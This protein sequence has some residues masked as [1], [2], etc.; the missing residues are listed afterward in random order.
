M[1]WNMLNEWQLGK[2]YGGISVDHLL[3]LYWALLGYIRGVFRLPRQE[4][5][6]NLKIKS[7]SGL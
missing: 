7:S 3:H 1:R 5:E 2:S 4:L 6:T